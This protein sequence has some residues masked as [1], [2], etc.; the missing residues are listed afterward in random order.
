VLVPSLE[1]LLLVLPLLV[2]LVLLL[3]WVEQL[4]VLAVSAQ[5]PNK[6]VNKFLVAENIDE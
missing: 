5:L 6:W 4:N 1:P 2:S 3:L